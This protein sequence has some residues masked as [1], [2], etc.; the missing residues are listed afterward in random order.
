MTTADRPDP[1]QPRLLYPLVGLVALGL[2]VDMVWTHKLFNEPQMAQGVLTPAGELLQDRYQLGGA[3]L[4]VEAALAFLWYLVELRRDENT[5][6]VV[7][8]SRLR[9]YAFAALAVPA[10]FVAVDLSQTHHFV[11][12]PEKTEVVVGQ[13]VDA[14]GNTVD[15]TEGAL[16]DIGRTQWR[17]DL[18]FSVLLFVG[19]MATLAWAARELALP[20]PFLVADDEGLLVRVDGP[21]RPPRRFLWEGIVEVRSGLLEDDGEKAPVLS[22]R[23]LDIEEVPYLPAGGR[24]EPPWLHLYS[25]EWDLPAHQIAPFLDQRAA[26][27]RPVGEYE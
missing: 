6:F 15:V 16:T 19:G 10:I 21:G 20:S 14:A 17:R 2:A 1:T 24:A 4:L 3:L 13:T 22:I 8:R 27:P 9:L 11:P 7:G 25:D 26:R 18:I 12:E 5:D 23:L